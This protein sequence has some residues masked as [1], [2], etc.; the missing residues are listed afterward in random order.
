M[1]LNAK[2]KWGV[3]V[4]L[5][6][7]GSL[8]FSQSNPFELQNRTKQPALIEKG[9]EQTEKV[10]EGSPTNPFDRPV[11]KKKTP[12]GPTLEEIEL[13]SVTTGEITP[14]GFF[15]NLLFITLMI[16][17]VINLD[18]SIISNLLK[19][20]TNVNFSNLL[21]RDKKTPDQV[22]YVLLEVA[23]YFNLGLLA[24][25]AYR[26]FTGEGITTKVMLSC[27]GA[28]AL[29]YVVRHLSLTVLAN[30]FSVTKEALQYSFSINLFNIIN[31][32]IL[33][34]FNFVIAFA[35]D[36]I[37]TSMIYLGIAVVAI[38]YIYRSIRGLLMAAGYLSTAQLHFLLYLCTCEILP[39][40][41][42]AGYIS[43]IS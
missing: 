3:L 9:A 36:A 32:L 10:Q 11:A 17:I 28:V 31:G 8:G 34:V 22:Q 30:T 35:P 26:Q 21:H 37:G 38:Q 5:V 1:Q 41:L 7:L 25:F 14:K 43:Q 27:I 40:A 15:W 42:G 24:A 6:C 18:R 29:I 23:Y 13:P 33:L 20:W 12:S 19:G 39:F 4:L 16:A 2:V